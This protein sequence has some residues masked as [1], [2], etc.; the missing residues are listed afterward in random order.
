[1]SSA[2]VVIG[3]ILAP[4]AIRLMSGLLFGVGP[5]DPMTLVAVPTLLALISIAASTIPAMR[6]ARRASVSFR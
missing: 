3:I 4:L 5:Y 1:M 2:A 6:A